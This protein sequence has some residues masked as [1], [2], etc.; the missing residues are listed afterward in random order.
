M[1]RSQFT[2]V[3]TT[4]DLEKRQAFKTNL[5]N[6]IDTPRNKEGLVVDCSFNGV[7]P[8]GKLYHPSLGEGTLVEVNHVD[9]EVLIDFV[10][11]GLIGLVLTQARS[12]VHATLKEDTKIVDDPFI[13]EEIQHI[14]LDRSNMAYRTI[15]TSKIVSPDFTSSEKF[16]APEGSSVWHP[17]LGA[18]KVVSVDE[19]ANKLTLS[20]SSNAVIDMILSQVRSKLRPVEGSVEHVPIKSVIR[21]PL[22]KKVPAYMARDDVSVKLPEVFKSWQRNQQFLF[23]TKS[24]KLTTEQANDVFS[25]IEGMKPLFHSVTLN[26]ESLEETA[27]SA[28]PNLTSLSIEDHG[29]SYNTNLGILDHASLWHPDFGQCSMIS[30]DVKT[31]E[32]ILQTSIGQKPFV[33]DVTV[34]KLAVLAGSPEHATK[35]LGIKE[36]EKPVKLNTLTNMTVALPGIFKSWKPAEQLQ[37]LGLT[38]KL[39]P[40]KSRDVLDLL[41]GKKILSGIEYSINWT[42]KLPE[43]D[44][45]AEF[46]KS[47]SYRVEAAS[48][49]PV[50]VFQVPVDSGVKRI[51][52]ENITSKKASILKK[53]VVDLPSDFTGW[54]AIGQNIFLTR[55]KLLTPDE[56][57]DVF[58]IIHGRGVLNNTAEFEIVWTDPISSGSVEKSARR[59]MEDEETVKKSSALKKLEVILPNDF[60]KWTASGQ[61]V[62]LTRTKQLTSTE[63]NDVMD[64]LQGKPVNS[65][66]VYEVNWS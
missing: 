17:D 36:A 41:E 54:T 19:T 24:Q 31:N 34:P 1:D 13:G 3:E 50:A 58:N 4:N 63:A 38:C 14:P 5:L 37:Y 49:D 60:K 53:I 15:D 18:C 29:F 48:I 40:E 28:S 61:Y 11:K 35:R 51:I 26:W 64:I 20:T 59:I 42:D 52:E 56:A 47:L 55:T 10:S 25:V 33:L 46:K 6:K 23:L 43:A 27:S 30:F 57:D 12:F 66:I 21:E 8:G 32:L 2:R 45:R 7:L 22:A 9:N 65:K 16:F 44:K 39:S 62:F